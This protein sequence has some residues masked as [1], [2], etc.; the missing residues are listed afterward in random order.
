[1]TE[2]F[3]TNDWQSI[4]VRKSVSIVDITPTVQKYNGIF[5]NHLRMGLKPGITAFSKQRS[6][7]LLSF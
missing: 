6:S 7:L 4:A 3:F 1:M 5:N 2:T